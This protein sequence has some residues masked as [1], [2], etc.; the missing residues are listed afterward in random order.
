MKHNINYL[1]NGKISQNYTIKSTLVKGTK[2]KNIN[3]A[4]NLSYLKLFNYLLFWLTI[5]QLGY[6]FADGKM[7]KYKTSIF[8]TISIFSYIYLF[9]KFDS[10]T[11]FMSVSGY[12]L[13][14]ISNEDPPTIYYLI[15]FWRKSFFLCSIKT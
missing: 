3:F 5:H 14:E 8:A 1:N 4:L 13:S 12:R 6:F 7:F 2:I 10:S 15:S 9:Y 11:E